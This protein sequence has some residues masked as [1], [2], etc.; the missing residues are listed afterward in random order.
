MK[1]YILY[2]AASIGDA[3]KDSLEKCG[4]NIIGYI[5][6]RAFELPEYNGLPVWGMENIPK[7]YVDSD[8]IVYI[9]VK[10]VFEH[11]SIALLLRKKGFKNIIYK[12]YSVLL[13]YG[14]KE[15]N[16]IAQIYDILFEGNL[17]NDFMLPQ[18]GA[19]KSYH[20]FAKIYEEDNQITAY[21]PAEFIFT[22]NYESP[23]MEKWGNICILAFFTHIDFFRFLNNHSDAGPNDYLQEFCVFAANIQ[24]KIKVTDAWKNNVIENRTQ[25]YEQMKDA[26]DLDPEFFIRNAA[27]AEWNVDKKYFNL[28]SGKHR[29]SF[30]AAMGK[31]YIPIKITKE[32]YNLFLNNIAVEDT[33]HL[34]EQMQKN[35]NIPHPFF[36]RGMFARDN[37]EY[38]FLS[39]FARH[40]SRKT[41]FENGKISFKK[42]KI[43]D[44]TNDFGNF[45][46][47]AKRLGC[48][49]QRHVI[50]ESLEIQLNKLFYS[51]N[52]AYDKPSE[53]I[54]NNI[55]VVEADD[56]EHEEI[57][58]LA[59]DKNIWIVKYADYHTIN[60]F[61]E[62][63]AL[64]IVSEI[65]MKYCA[66]AILH[67]FLLES[68][69][70]ANRE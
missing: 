63:Y 34:V 13:G 55:I 40:F 31:K 14:S 65:N 54:E 38:H 36:Y 6:R 30:Q 59:T 58:Q 50:P 66:G 20:D 2:G 26:L 49:T 21:I 17:V 45:A 60:S 7:E 22:N 32:D 62:K 28:T 1:Q 67:S 52:I 23:V 16:E 25:I 39:W 18:I 43:I 24:K 69:S 64:H 33:M 41:Y 56:L 70:N 47:F 11:E 37:S 9:S 61:A 68:K 51:E 48:Q 3:A 8:V 35:V 4:A 27:E 42:L 44:Y 19:K 12:P 53:L 15:E 10:N 57:K 46:R 29:C 5:D